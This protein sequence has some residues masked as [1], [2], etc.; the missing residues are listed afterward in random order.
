MVEVIQ[1][2]N[3]KDYPKGKKLAFLCVFYTFG[4][5]TTEANQDSSRCAMPQNVVF[6]NKGE[7]RGHLLTTNLK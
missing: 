5:L 4:C 7:K 6:W 1:I 3:R 2:H